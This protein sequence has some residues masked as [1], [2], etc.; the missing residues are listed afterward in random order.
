MPAFGPEG[1]LRVEVQ[2]N[3]GDIASLRRKLHG[4]PTVINSSLIQRARDMSS[5]AVTELNRSA[6]VG[7]GDPWRRGNPPL[8]QSHHAQVINAYYAVV[9]SEAPHALF[10]VTGFTPHMPPAEAWTGEP[11]EGYPKRLAVLRNQTPQAPR[12]YF[13]PVVDGMARYNERTRNDLEKRVDAQL[14]S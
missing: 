9:W 1:S 13:T 14:K 2:V 7:E 12:D 3:T 5:Q 11:R 6:P 4:L 10:I 8:S